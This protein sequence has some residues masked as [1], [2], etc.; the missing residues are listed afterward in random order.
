[1]LSNDNALTSACVPTA[2][3]AGV[4]ASSL[5]NATLTLSLN[6]LIM[7][8]VKFTVVSFSPYV[9]VNNGETSLIVSV[10]GVICTV[11]FA[12]F[13]NTNPPG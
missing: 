12:L 1:M 8:V 9:L 13:A 4:P 10:A 7:L 2:S 5:A 6:W 11:M 3:P